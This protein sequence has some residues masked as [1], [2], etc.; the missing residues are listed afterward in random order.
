MYVPAHFAMTDEQVAQ[1]LA[2]MRAADLVTPH[3]DGL[4]ATYLPFLYDPGRGE[5]GALLTHVARNNRQWSVPTTGPALVIVHATD[6]Y[7]SP[8]WLPSTA[9]HGKVVPTWDYVTVHVYGQLVA[10]D[11]PAF[12]RAVVTRLTERHEGGLRPRWAVAD[13]PDGYVEAMLRAIVA[14]EVQVTRIEAKAKMAQNKTPADVSALADALE[15]QGDTD[16]AAWLRERSLPAAQ[17]R[18]DTLAQVARRGGL[19]D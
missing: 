10:H 14:L 16:G 3:A 6:H 9:E 11:D 13:P 1:V 7:V 2:R 12:T 4:D 15:A 18:A 17:H 5:R 19:R 8:S